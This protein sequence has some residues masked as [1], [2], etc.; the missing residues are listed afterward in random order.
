MDPTTLTG[1]ISILREGGVY[2]CLALLGWAYWRQVGRKDGELKALYERLVTLAEGQTA[3]LTKVH[4]ALRSL[5]E[6]IQELR[7]RV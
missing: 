3:A 6:A 2:A 5:R 1:A 4:E 7:R